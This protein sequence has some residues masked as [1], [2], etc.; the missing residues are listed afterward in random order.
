MSS[1]NRIIEKFDGATIWYIS[2]DPD[3]SPE[4]R[5]KDH[6][7]YSNINRSSFGY[8]QPK[9]MGNPGALILNEEAIGGTRKTTSALWVPKKDQYWTQCFENLIVHE[10]A[11]SSLRLGS[12]DRCLKESLRYSLRAFGRSNLRRSS[13]SLAF[14][15][16]GLPPNNPKSE[17][18]DHCAYHDGECRHEHRQCLRVL[19]IDE[20]LPAPGVSGLIHFRK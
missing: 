15:R 16:N 10:I 18:R 4:R 17:G 5:T 13:L 20:P 1:I 19:A 3:F 12:I 2:R 7:S 9:I 11:V 6:T 8:F 14:G